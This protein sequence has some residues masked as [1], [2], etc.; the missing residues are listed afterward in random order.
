MQ[1][2][3]A[4]TGN[5][6]EPCEGV[7]LLLLHLTGAKSGRERVNPLG[8][9]PKQAAGWSVPPMPAHPHATVEMGTETCDVQAVVLQ[10]KGRDEI[11]AQLAA[12]LFFPSS[13]AGMVSIVSKCS[14][15]L[16][17]SILHKS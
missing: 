4:T 14:V 1:E 17:F 15:I 9:L 6:G 8:S 5:V 12:L 3:R 7:S 10:G 13:L 11:L 16:P 2:F